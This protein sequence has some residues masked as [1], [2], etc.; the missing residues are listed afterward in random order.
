MRSG[1]QRVPSYHFRNDL[2]GWR[3]RPIF[4]A[5]RLRAPR[6]DHTRDEARV[7]A[8][9]VRDTRNVVE[10]GAFEGGGSALTTTHY[11]D[12]SIIYDALTEPAGR[13]RW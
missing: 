10:I 8:A 13:R 1:G 5:L 7:I 11:R 6:G 4:G 3:N 9:A 12:I 2:S